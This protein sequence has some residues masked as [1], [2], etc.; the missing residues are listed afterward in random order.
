MLLR[1]ELC[2]QQKGDRFKAAVNN[3]FYVL[4]RMLCKRA[5]LSIGAHVGE[6]GRGSFT[7]TFERQMK[8]GSGNGAFFIVLCGTEEKISVHVLCECE[9]W[10]SHTLTHEYMGSFFWTLRIS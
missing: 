2:V 5:N 6:P 4:S 7:G 9:T 1:Q 3:S 8:E 10:G